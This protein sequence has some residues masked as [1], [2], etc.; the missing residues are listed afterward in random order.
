MARLRAVPA[1][2]RVVV[3]GVLLVGVVAGVLAAGVVFGDA[4]GDQRPAAV[5]Q[6]T[7]SRAF[8]NCRDCHA[9]LDAVFAQP[10]RAGMRFRHAVHFEKASSQCSD[11]H[12][13]QPHSPTGTVKPD[14]ERCFACHGTGTATVARAGGVIAPGTCV[15]CHVPG[16]IPK[17]ATHASKTWVTGQHGQ[18]ALSASTK[19][20]CAGCHTEKSCSSCHGV[21]MP[22]PAGF[23]G[24]GHVATVNKVGA[25]VC[26]RCHGGS[27]SSRVG[28]S[29]ESCHHPM[30][31]AGQSMRSFHPDYIEHRST[32]ECAR[33]H[34]VASFCTRCHGREGEGGDD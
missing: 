16:T 29:C 3:L 8:G 30:K 21:T 13:A 6:P 33:C 27:S 12:V 4:D 18:Q 17:P 34:T 32:A 14:H 5:A 9:D 24:G 20:T 25:A 10:A 1:G 22:H 28:S 11:C 31:P 15:T 7:P 2:R 23:T 26:Q 19:A